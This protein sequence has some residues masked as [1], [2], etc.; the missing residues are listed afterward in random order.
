MISHTHKGIFTAIPKTGTSTMRRVLKNKDWEFIFKFKDKNSQHDRA[1]HQQE[2]FQKHNYDYNSYFKF[3]FVRNPWERCLSAHRWFVRRGDLSNTPFRGFICDYFSNQY[4]QSPGKNFFQK[5]DL[6][7]N[8]INDQNGN[9]LLD[10]V[11]KTENF[12][13]D[14][15]TICDKIKIPRKQLPHKN[16]TKHK[17]Y[18]EY[19]DDE[20]KQ[21]IAEKYAKD[22]EYFG[23]KFGE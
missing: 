12:K 20:T 18:T 21:I 23:Y 7:I 13:E 4:K 17:H 16:K 6:Q 11:G 1:I 15:N 8:W 5:M 19:Y 9:N 14:F 22:I 2:Y 3:A 10:F